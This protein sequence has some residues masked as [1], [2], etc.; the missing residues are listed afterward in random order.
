M[1]SPRPTARKRRRAVSTPRTTPIAA[2]A[3]VTAAT[4]SGNHD[5]AG[6][7]EQVPAQ[8]R[9]H[10]RHDAASRLRRSTPGIAVRT[11]RSPSWATTERAIQCWI[12]NV[13]AAPAK[14]Q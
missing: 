11:E 3:S 6:A 9:R 1:T 10:E 4:S 8:P 5:V 13:R 7:E 14:D 12:G 2:D